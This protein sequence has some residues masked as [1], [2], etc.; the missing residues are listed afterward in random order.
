MS[1]GSAATDGRSDRRRRSRRAGLRGAGQGADSP[2][3]RAR[4]SGGGTR[5]PGRRGRRGA[6]RHR[7]LGDLGAARARRRRARPDSLAGGHRASLLCRRF[8]R[9]GGD[10]RCAGDRCRRGLSRR[11]GDRVAVRRRATHDPRRCRDPARHGGARRRRVSAERLLAICL[12]HQARPGRPHRGARGDHRPGADLRVRRRAGDADRQLGR[13]RAACDRKHRLHDRLAVRAGALHLPRD[14][15][16]AAARR[17]PLHAGD[18]QPRHDL[19]H[20]L[21]AGRGAP[22]AR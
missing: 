20:R 22:D 6:A 11:R 21:G 5:R 1:N 19:P 4:R 14:H 12:R 15:R 9:L 16:D 3:R 2:R 10:G 8:D 17:H 18:H 7:A 13:A